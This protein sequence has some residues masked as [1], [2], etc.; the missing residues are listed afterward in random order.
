[1]TLLSIRHGS[2]CQAYLKLDGKLM[3]SENVEAPGFWSKD[4]YCLHLKLG[5]FHYLKKASANGRSHTIVGLRAYPI[6]MAHAPAQQNAC[7]ILVEVHPI[8]YTL[9]QVSFPRIIEPGEPSNLVLTLTSL[10]GSMPEEEI[11]KELP[12]LFKL[13]LLP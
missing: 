9:G 11:I 7:R 3:S 10:D 2:N 5:E 4:G 8:F 13:Y 1:M 12:Y 6:Q